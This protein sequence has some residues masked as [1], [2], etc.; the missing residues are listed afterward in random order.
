MSKERKYS[1]IIFAHFYEG[2]SFQSCITAY[3]IPDT[4]LQRQLDFFR[5]NK[6]SDLDSYL[7]SGAD[8][9]LKIQ[10]IELFL[11]DKG[12]AKRG[13]K[14]A[15]SPSKVDVVMNTLNT[16]S[17]YDLGIPTLILRQMLA[18]MAGIGETNRFKYGLPSNAYITA[19]LQKHNLVSCSNK[20]GGKS[21]SSFEPIQFQ[22]LFQ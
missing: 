9:E 17:E 7:R 10:R 13:P 1:K 8:R 21:C 5:D 3:K 12:S 20:T 4:T 19:F 2:I 22:Q 14:P 15:V 18:D 11:R 16:W 6:S